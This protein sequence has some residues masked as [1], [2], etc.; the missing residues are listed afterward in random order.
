MTKPSSAFLPILYKLD[1]DNCHKLRE[2]DHEFIYKV[3]FG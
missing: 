3:G 1:I 2:K